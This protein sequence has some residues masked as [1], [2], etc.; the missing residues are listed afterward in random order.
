MSSNI[1]NNNNYNLQSIPLMESKLDEF[2]YAM[3]TVEGNSLSETEMREFFYEK[4]Y[5]RI[6]CGSISDYQ[7]NKLQWVMLDYFK[8]KKY[9]IKREVNYGHLYVMPPKKHEIEVGKNKSIQGYEEATIYLEKK[10]GRKTIKDRIVINISENYH[11]GGMH[12]EIQYNEEKNKDIFSEWTKMADEKNFYKGQKIDVGCRILDLS[13]T[14][15]DDVI[16]SDEK[17]KAIKESVNDIFDNA[18]TLKKFGISIQRGLILHGDPGTGKTQICRALAHEAKC[19]VLYALPT[20]FQKGPSGVRTVTNI[21]KDL[22]PCILIIEDMD[23]IAMDRDAGRAGFVMEL[24]NQMDGIEAFG[25]IITIGTTNRKDDLEDAVSNRPGR[26]DRIIE[27]G[28][29]EKE[30]IEKMIISFCQKWDISRV[31]LKKVT[32]TL[33]SL[34]G[35]HIKEFCKTSAIY[36]VRGKSFSDDG[37]T[38][39]LKESHFKDAWEEV[40]NKDMSSYLETKAKADSGE[41]FGFAQ[42][43][44]DPDD[45]IL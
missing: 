36:A 28:Y 25:D 45:F 43:T 18:D 38:L 22:A 1:S 37:D 24:M 21:A 33:E 12:Y 30:E 16:I 29:P 39:I 41:S 5:F 3:K 8:S 9:E 20:D 27:I 14:T 7:H 31:D 44:A 40:K 34:S 4:S 32:N 10:G 19:S 13:K 6:N 15:W 23:W 2:V 17:K 26:F 35:A 42:K 11:L